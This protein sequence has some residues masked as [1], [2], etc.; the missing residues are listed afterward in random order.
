[1]TG[2]ALEG[3]VVADF[4]R[5]LAGPLLAMTLGDLGADVVKVESPAGDDTRAGGPPFDADGRATY[6]QAAN[7]NKR[8]IAL[9]LG[10]DGDRRLARLLCER[11]DVVVANFRPGVLERFGLGYAEVSERAPGVVYCEVSGFGEA[12]G[13][14]LPGYDPLAQ[15]LG[16]LMSVTGPPGMPSK[17]GV[18]LVDIIAGLYGTVAVLSALHE[19]RSSGR[20]QRIALNLLHTTL[21]A[22][23][24]QA[25]GW[26][27]AR[28]VPTLQGNLHPSIEPFGTY[29]A[30]DGDLMICAGNDRQFA[31]LV[32]VLGV[33]DAGDDPRF[34]TNAERVAN[35]AAL[36][37]VLEQALAARGCVEW[38]DLLMAA[39]VPAGPVQGVPEA[40]A[41]AESLGLEVVDATDGVR[42]VAF[43][44]SLSR[45]PAATRR[46]PP[47]LDEHGD[48]I[49]AW[50]D[51]ARPAR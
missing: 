25:T 31:A 45:T 22:L 43:P 6:F 17:T 42:T 11:A 41:F 1:V 4:S 40:F 21:A 20:G 3:I 8:S 14:E 13:R 35:R 46:R 27:G 49:R 12:G 47:E 26:L 2:A 39:R 34:R 5:V 24:N 9:D 37:A 28:T 23:A 51:G 36:R 19:R 16:G 48:E 7:R 30:R 18:A 10:D 38:R 50:L 32:G 33:R 44:A 15:A 29:R